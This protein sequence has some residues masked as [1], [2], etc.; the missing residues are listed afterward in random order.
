MQEGNLAYAVA[1]RNSS[2]EVKFFSFRPTV[3]L[4]VYNDLQGWPDTCALRTRPRTEEKFQF[5]KLGDAKTTDR[6]LW[7]MNYPMPPPGQVQTC[8]ITRHIVTC[9]SNEME[10]VYENIVRKYVDCDTACPHSQQ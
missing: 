6:H 5:E 4:V 8:V 10:Y 3:H 1:V 9:Q 7:H 2:I